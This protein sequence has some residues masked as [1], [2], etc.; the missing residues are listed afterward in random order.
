[1]HAEY[2]TRFQKLLEIK[3]SALNGL[4]IGDD[5]SFEKHQPEFC[6]SVHLT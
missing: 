2:I 6:T 3:R 5:G 1:M 4:P